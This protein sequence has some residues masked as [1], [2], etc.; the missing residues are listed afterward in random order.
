MKRN[1]LTFSAQLH[2]DSIRINF[3]FP[4]YQNYEN[5]FHAKLHSNTLI[6]CIHD[7]KID[8]E[9]LIKKLVKFLRKSP[10]IVLLQFVDFCTGLW[11]T[12]WLLG[13]EKN[14]R[15]S[16]TKKCDNYCPMLLRDE[17]IIDNYINHFDNNYD[18]NQNDKFDQSQIC[19]YVH[20]SKKQEQIESYQPGN[21][22]I[23]GDFV[24]GEKLTSSM[25]QKLQEYTD[26]QMS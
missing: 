8:N 9:M 3:E 18:A 5:V 22:L 15:R 17:E 19:I 2:P 12:G 20:F 6:K 11:G 23:L 14:N 13:K 10:S 26:K 1:E 16:G 24:S 7:K 4:L 21:I 25:L